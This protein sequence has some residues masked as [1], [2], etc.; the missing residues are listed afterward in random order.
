LFALAEAV[1]GRAVLVVDEAYQEFSRAPGAVALLERFP[2]LVVLRTLSKAHALAGARIGVLLGAPPLVRLLRN[3]SAPYPIAVPSAELALRALSPAALQRTAR[4]VAA[5]LREREWLAPRLA[6]LAGVRRVHPSDANFLLVRFD[7]ARAAQQRLLAAGVVV[8]EMSA[9][10]G[11]GD[12]LRITIGT[13]REGEA[14]LAALEC[15]A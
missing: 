10:P 12:A 13:R 7:D 3:L 8:R 4:R 1:R 11:L 15:P 6:A 5:T 9:M 2:E 14:L